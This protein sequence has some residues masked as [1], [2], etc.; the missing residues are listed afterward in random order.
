M[1]CVSR[2]RRGINAAGQ[3]CFVFCNSFATQAR[4]PSELSLLG[5]ALA[6]AAVGRCFVIT[7]SFR[8]AGRR[9]FVF[10]CSFVTQARMPSELS[11]LGFAL[12]WA[13]VGRCFV[14]TLSFRPAGRKFFGI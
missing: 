7:L 1:A 8:P 10:F 2:R 4:M 9:V 14:I 13:A 11:L 5:F 6:W 12:A 3:R